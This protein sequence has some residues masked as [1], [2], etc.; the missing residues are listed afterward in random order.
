MWQS[1]RTSH[2][3]SVATGS[4]DL[5]HYDDK[6]LSIHFWDKITGIGIPFI[7]YSCISFLDYRCIGMKLNL[8]LISLSTG[9]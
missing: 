6:V 1:G 5:W 2:G 8:F 3:E 9:K 7:S 4:S